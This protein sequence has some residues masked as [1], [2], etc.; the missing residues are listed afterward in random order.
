MVAV[1]LFIHLSF[2]IRLT[3]LERMLKTRDRGP[4]RMVDPKVVE[5]LRPTNSSR[6]YQQQFSFKGIN[7]A[8][9]G[10]SRL[11]GSLISS[12]FS[13]IGLERLWK[14]LER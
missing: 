4:E 12:A 6:H 11:T 1:S 5:T 10:V 13:I 8:A 2:T 9:E 14:K 7:N 3:A